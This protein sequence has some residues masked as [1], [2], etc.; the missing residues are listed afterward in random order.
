MRKQLLFTLRR[1]VPIMLLLLPGNAWARVFV[2]WTQDVVPPAKALG[3]SELVI[4]WKPDRTT[5]V[6]NAATEGYRV[7]VESTAQQAGNIAN[8]VEKYGAT[9]IIVNPEGAPPASLDRD[10]QK[11]RTAHPKLLFRL[12]NP[13]ALQP[14]MKGTL[15]INKD[16]VL[17]V[18]SPTAQPWLDTNLALVKMEQAF[19]PE[20]VP[21]YSFNW[22]SIGTAQQQGPEASDYALAVAESG[23]FKADLILS[24]HETLQS[25]LAQNDPKAWALWKPIT[26]YLHFYQQNGRRLIPEANVAVVTDDNPDSFEAINLLARHNI[27]VRVLRPNQ[28]SQSTLHNFDIIILFP[29]LGLH[30]IEAI[31]EFAAS[32]RTAV[33]VNPPERT[34]PW[35][36]AKGISTGDASVSYSR[37]KGKIIELGAPISDPETFAVDIRRLVDNSKIQISLWNALTTVGVLYREPQ[38]ENEIVE[39]VNYAE[40]PVEVQIRVKGAFPVIR[41]ESPEGGCCK[42]L[43]PVIRD[44]FTEFAVPSLMITGRVHLEKTSRVKAA[45]QT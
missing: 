30:L 31:S 2:R 42:T 45:P 4:P 6:R 26:N 8:S 27:P 12:A 21:L 16:G 43:S 15:V 14:Q 3:V 17:Q 28:L 5:L 32:G 13:N 36:S 25:G 35:H 11:L 10:I 23:A 22:N 9:G 34:Y 1:F 44:G 19:R 37:G 20:Q 41:Y 33:L 29:S 40:D 18:T 24:L 39:L 38:S 7:Y